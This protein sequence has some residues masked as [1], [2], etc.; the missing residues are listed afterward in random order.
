[1]HDEKG[2]A[3]EKAVFITLDDLISLKGKAKAFSLFKSKSASLHS[4]GHK[5]HLLARGMEFA[6][7]RRYQA[8]DDIRTIDWRVTARTGKPHTKLFSEERE[9]SIYTCIDFRS[10]M[11]FATQGVF[12][13]VQAA[14]IASLIA[15]KAATSGD[16]IGGLI[17]DNY[18]LTEKRPMRGKSG[19]LPLLE[20]ISFS[21]KYS[22]D[23]MVRGQIAS[24]DLALSHIS[25]TVRPGS[26]VYI[27]SDFR[28]CG[29]NLNTYLHKIASHSQ[30][31]LCFLYDP[32]E[33][34]LPSHNSFAITDGKSSYSLQTHSKKMLDAYK[35]QFN[36]RKEQLKSVSQKKIHFTM[37]ATTDDPTNMTLL[38]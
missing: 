8:G 3:D 16:R 17:F 14:K 32:V 1:M 23:K 38:D 36:Q 25:T 13:S 18:G 15:W 33:E 5:S 2:I 26:L 10:P 31:V 11:F 20:S 7:T 35:Q 9:R 22:E 30:V 34:E 27:I 28:R 4:G 24:M 6:E 29:I 19:V 12:K 37:C 21:A